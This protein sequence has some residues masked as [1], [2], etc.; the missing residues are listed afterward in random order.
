MCDKEV[1]IFSL[2]GKEP[3]ELFYVQK[4]SLTLHSERPVSSKMLSILPDADLAFCHLCVNV[5]NTVIYNL[6]DVTDVVNYVAKT[7]GDF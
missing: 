3:N 1:M 2:E 6:K 4:L 7:P 5:V